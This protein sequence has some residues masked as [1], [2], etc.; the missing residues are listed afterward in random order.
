VFVA[1]P[2]AE[3]EDDGVLLTVVLDAERNTSYLLILDAK[4]LSELP[5]GC[6]AGTNAHGHLSFWGIAWA[7]NRRPTR[8]SQPGADVGNDD[9]IRRLHQPTHFIHPWVAVPGGHGTIA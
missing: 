7:M 2:N 3:S 5:A 4:D 1:R 6:G 9:D 8:V